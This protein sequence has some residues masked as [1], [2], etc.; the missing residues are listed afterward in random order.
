M[1][2]AADASLH[3]MRL[4]LVVSGFS[5]YS[6]EAGY[7]MKI[8]N[9]K[10]GHAKYTIKKAEHDHIPLI[11]EIEFAAATIFP[12]NS[13]PEHILSEKLPLDILLAA[14]DQDMLWVAVDAEDSP[15][16][17]I[18]LQIINGLAILAQ[19]DVH[20]NHGQKG[21]GTA[22]VIHG[23]EQI[24]KLGFSELY[25]T[26][27]S[28]IKWN[29]PFYSKIGFAILKENEIPAPIISILHAE[30]ERGLNDRVAMR[31]EIS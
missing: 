8:A 28:T 21:I 23:I 18:L 4:S 9:C 22:L 5:D 1:T 2:Q 10:T 11:N 29:A 6:L 19:I 24:R 20:P 27:F 13:F 26:T 17:Y 3:T 25:L 30:L 16:G 31:L 7:T 12:E 14:K 15:V